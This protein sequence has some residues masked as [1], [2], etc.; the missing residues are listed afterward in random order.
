LPTPSGLARLTAW[1]KSREANA[2]WHQLRQA[3]LPTL[4]AK[5]NDQAKRA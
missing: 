1:A 2:I 3:T 4:R 5:T